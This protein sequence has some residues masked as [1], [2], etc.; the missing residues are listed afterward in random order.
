MRLKKWLTYTKDEYETIS[1]FVIDQLGRIP[2]AEEKPE[3]EFN[4]LVFKVEEVDEKRITKV[5][6]CRAY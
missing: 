4:R 1:G 5:K 2:G 3:I 6:V